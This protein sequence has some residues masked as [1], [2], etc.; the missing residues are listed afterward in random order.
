MVIKSIMQR[1]WQTAFQRLCLKSC[2][3][4]DSKVYFDL[5]SPAWTCSLKARGIIIVILAY[6]VLYS[7]YQQLL[8]ISPQQASLCNGNRHTNSN[9]IIHRS[10][11]TPYRDP[12]KRRENAYKPKRKRSKGSKKKNSTSGYT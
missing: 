1:F 2:L 9:G 8:A 5:D 6:R 3:L 11:N 10:N 12:N 4:R 7:K